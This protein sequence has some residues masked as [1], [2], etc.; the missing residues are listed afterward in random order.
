MVVESIIIGSFNISNIKNI[1]YFQ[2]SD[3]KNVHNGHELKITE[4]I[5][6]SYSMIVPTL[7]MAMD[8]LKIISTNIL[9]NNANVV[10]KIKNLT[11]KQIN[12]EKYEAIINSDYC[13][14]IVIGICSKYDCKEIQ[15]DMWQTS[16]PII[17][18][19]VMCDSKEEGFKLIEK[20][21]NNF[22]LSCLNI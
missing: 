14:N 10:K 13:E 9:N 17:S 21:F 6:C 20:F 15:V 1:E 11:W 22:I 2:I 12:N 16:I 19:H 3:Y 8:C 7:E 5:D 18:K 4:S